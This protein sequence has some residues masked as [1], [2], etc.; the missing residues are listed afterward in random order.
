M[1]ILKPDQRAFLIQVAWSTEVIDAIEKRIE[2]AARRYKIAV[3]ASAAALL[4]GVAW[5]FYT[6]P[7]SDIVFYSSL[8][9]YLALSFLL[10]IVARSSPE[11]RTFR[12]LV[13][14]ISKLNDALE[15]PAAARE[16]EALAEQLINCANN[17]RAY[18]AFLSFGL[19]ERIVSREATRGS[20][21][22]RNLIYPALLGTNEELQQIK[23][24]LA[25]AAIR[26][27]TANWVQVGDLDSGTKDYAVVKSTPAWVSPQTLT[28]F[29][30]AVIPL[31]IA[32]L[33]L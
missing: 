15:T 17:M 21:A 14:A 29:M 32:L 5:F 33:K 30:I 8:A 31:I 26:V 6:I 28:P 22:L 3:S 19:S 4:A 13:N 25:R 16:R 11:Y 10:A 27:G 1:V 23:E 2:P 9:L 12:A 18:R 7:K 20:R 24:V